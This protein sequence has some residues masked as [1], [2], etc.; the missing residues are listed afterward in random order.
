MSGTNIP[1]GEW[2]TMMDGEAHAQWKNWSTY[3]E[4]LNVST[5]GDIKLHG[6]EQY[7]GAASGYYQTSYTEGSGRAATASATSY[8]APANFS[9]GMS[10]ETT[11]ME[12]VLEPF[13]FRST[14]N[15]DQDSQQKWV[16][17][18]GERGMVKIIATAD[19]NLCL[20]VRLKGIYSRMPYKLYCELAQ[21]DT[22]LT[23]G[24]S[25]LDAKTG[26]LECGEFP[27]TASVG[28]LQL[29]VKF[30]EPTYRHKNLILQFR[31]VPSEFCVRNREIS[32]EVMRLTCS[33]KTNEIEVI[34]STSWRNRYSQSQTT[35]DRGSTSAA[36]DSKED[37]KDGAMVAQISRLR[38]T[39][40][41]EIKV[42]E[43]REIWL[44]QNWVSRVGWRVFLNVLKHK[45]GLE[46]YVE[47]DFLKHCV[48]GDAAETVERE[49][50]VFDFNKIFVNLRSRTQI[51]KEGITEIYHQYFKHS[52]FCGWSQDEYIQRKLK[53]K[54]IG[55]FLIRFSNRSNFCAMVVK[56]R[57]EAEPEDMFLKYLLKFDE[58]E[59]SYSIIYDS[60]SRS[61]NTN[62]SFSSLLELVEFYYE[63]PVPHVELNLCLKPTNWEFVR[64]DYGFADAEAE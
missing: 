25:Q 17:E 60:P 20:T 21:G 59:Q 44:G 10:F 8:P 56:V 62:P 40:E 18:E 29:E 52:W 32:D 37:A 30:I 14:R 4:N 63:N 23:I 45:L 36:T 50:D 48:G 31:A 51:S 15:K 12:L 53:P 35:M 42:P 2:D 46:S 3:G 58:N 49:I 55:C 47:L 57:E 6:G 38:E 22:R 39:A 54:E 24:K 43:A 19:K 16:R 1:T 34:S 61:T 64:L 27:A 33:A 5:A 28:E 11:P 13:S 7:S 41:R 26:M 9:S